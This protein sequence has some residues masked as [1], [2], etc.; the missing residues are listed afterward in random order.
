MMNKVHILLRGGVE[1]EKA[2]QSIEIRFT[3]E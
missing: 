1:V 2:A 3:A